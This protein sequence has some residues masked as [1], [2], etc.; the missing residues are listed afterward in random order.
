MASES[1]GGPSG[2]GR[3]IMRNPGPD[4]PGHVRAFDVLVP[5]GDGAGGNFADGISTGVGIVELHSNGSFG[6][7]PIQVNRNL[8]INNG[9]TTSG[10]TR[11]AHSAIILDGAATLTA[12]VPQDLGLFDVA[13][14]EA[15][16]TSTTGSGTLVISSPA[17]MALRFTT[18]AYSLRNLRRHPI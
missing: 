13:Y 14:S 18:K 1:S 3:F 5:H 6:T 17:L 12:G 15:T 11:S 8:V 16:G 2:V 4:N 7:R 9:S 10:G